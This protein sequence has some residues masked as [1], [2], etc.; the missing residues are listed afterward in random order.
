MR[1]TLPLSVAAATLMALSCSSGGPAACEGSEAIPQQSVEVGEDVSVTAICFEDPSGGT[2][3]ISASSADESVVEAF[4]RGSV[5]VRGVSPGQTTVTARAT[6][7][8]EKSTSVD[9]EVLVPNNPPA[10][11]MPDMTLPVGVD[12]AIDLAIVYTDPDGQALTYTVSSSSSTVASVAVTGSVLALRTAG[13]GLATVTVT[14][15]DGH[16]EHT[17]MFEV[18]AE[19][20][21][22]SDDFASATSLDDW[23]YTDST[24][25]T[26][27]EDSRLLLTSIHTGFLGVASQAIGGI[28]EDVTVDA[29][30]RP[31]AEALAGF[32]VGTTDSIVPL[33]V[34]LVGEADLGLGAFDWHFAWY[35]ATRPGW[36]AS[37]D[38]SLGT[39]DDIDVD[40]TAIVSLSLTSDE[41]LSVMLN[42]QEII[43]PRAVAIENTAVELSLWAWRTGEDARAAARMGW[44]GLRAED[45]TEFDDPPQSYKRFDF[46]ELSEVKRIQQYK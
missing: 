23:S 20:A 10:G 19:S 29:A 45:F 35:D 11:S 38:W 2:L 42:G 8:A 43:A 34:F 1:T 36:V 9:F 46:G 7:E 15:S 21:L 17:D 13:E 28:A 25:E 32:G 22:A 30:L 44:V 16:A 14:A 39:S 4:V 18:T 40:V 5:W 24:T 27:I 3:S 37:P 6:N 41:G 31:T 12:P 33:Y 26:A